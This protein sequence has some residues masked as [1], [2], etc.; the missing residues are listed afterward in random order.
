M[1]RLKPFTT[2]AKVAVHYGKLTDHREIGRVFADGTFR[3]LGGIHR[4]MPVDDR[5]VRQ[6]RQDV[7][8]E[9]E[10]Q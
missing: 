8:C 4:F 9:L 7:Y 6:D 2:G 3:L 5:A 1:P 10:Q